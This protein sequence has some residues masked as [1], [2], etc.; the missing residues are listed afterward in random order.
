MPLC[1]GANGCG[2]AL[3][4]TSL[5]ITGSGTAANPW[6]AELIGIIWPVVAS[7]TEPTA[8]DYGL[9]SI[10]VGAVWVVMP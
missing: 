8:A 10:P 1:M 4:S 5:S 3:Q 7:P 9:A 6:D 2:C